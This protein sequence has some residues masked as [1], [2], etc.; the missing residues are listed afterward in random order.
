MRK[1]GRLAHP[2][3]SALTTEVV[4]SE[5]VGVAAVSS[6]TTTEALLEATE[7]A[8]RTGEVVVAVVVEEATTEEVRHL[9]SLALHSKARLWEQ[10]GGSYYSAA[11]GLPTAWFPNCTASK[12]FD[13]LHITVLFLLVF[14]F[15]T[16]R[17]LRNLRIHL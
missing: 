14:P 5:A 6:V 1:A 3:K 7:E 15:L 16:I 8:S 13:Y 2:L 11:W 9:P 10:V 4:A 17:S 12:P